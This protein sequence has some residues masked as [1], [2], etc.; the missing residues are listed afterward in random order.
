MND[1]HTIRAE[2]LKGTTVF[3]TG[4]T[5][6]VGSH[7]AEYLLAEGCSEVR[8]LVRTEE[9]WLKDIPVTIVRG[10]LNDTSA[11]AEGVLGADYIFHVAALTRARTWQEFHDANVQGTLNL[12]ESASHQSSIK[13]VVITSSLAVVGRSVDAVADEQT[14]L[15]PVSQYGRSKHEMEIAIRDY[16]A[17]ITVVR[18]PAVYGPRETDIFTFFRTLSKGICPIV[19]SSQMPALSLVHVND[20]V[21]GIVRSA[22]SANS[23]G[24]T[25]FLGGPRPY[26]WGEIRDA[27]AGALQRKVITLRIPKAFVPAVGF[28]AETVGNVLG[29]YPPMNREKAREI[30]EATL[31]CDSTLASKTFGYNPKIDLVSGITETIR[32]YQQQNWL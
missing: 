5:G 8:C 29:F 20:L 32:W 14:R 11:L 13:R 6:F 26:S 15:S 7:L 18:P 25:F 17:P 21:G 3:L 28:V 27:V 19:G 4:G 12:L 10:T 24:K 1:P 9:K 22:I 2:S 31:M 23:S 16:T 30:V